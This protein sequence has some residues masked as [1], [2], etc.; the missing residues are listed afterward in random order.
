MSDPNPEFQPPPPPAVVAEPERPRPQN[1]M[2]AGVALIVIGIVIVVLGIP[3]IGLIIGGIGTG[4]AVC[5]LGILL[6]AFSFIRLPA[7]KDPPPKMST[8]ATLTGI[9]FEP[10]SVFRNL[11]AH[12][13]WLGAILIVGIVNGAYSVAFNHRLTPERIINFTMDK[14]EDSPIKPPPEAM[15]KARTEGVEQAKSLTFQ[16]GDFVK[17][18]VGAFFAVAFIA[19]LCLLGVLAFGGRMHYWQT[20]A[21]IAYVTFPATLIQKA[22]SFI[23]LYLKSP[24]DIHPLLGQESL[25]YDNLGLLVAAKDHPVIFVIATSIGVL[26]FYRLWLTATGL[27]EAGYKVSSSAAWG[28]TITIF[29]LFLLLGM[30]AAM[31][32]GSMFG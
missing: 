14:L 8:A 25:V 6:F 27:R 32:F 23:I 1:L 22:I 19:A 24:D 12:P 15:A 17:K 26:S 3:G 16:A 2:W 28:V 13:Q 30:A 4:A 31:L 11:R 9:F 10:T 21:A 20:Y 18:V 5:V 29:L 7:V